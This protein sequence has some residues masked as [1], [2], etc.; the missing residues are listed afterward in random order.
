M[1]LKLHQGHIDMS[2]WFDDD[3]IHLMKSEAYTETE[4]G[5]SD[6]ADFDL[7]EMIEQRIME[8][9]TEALGRS[10]R[11]QRDAEEKHTYNTVLYSLYKEDVIDKQ[12]Y[13][14]FFIVIE[15]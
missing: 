14:R 10:R 2:K 12:M 4:R 13:D 1:C 3:E 6:V 5:H 7:L 9:I 8:R 11:W 15:N